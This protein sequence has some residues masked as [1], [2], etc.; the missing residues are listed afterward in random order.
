MT[1]SPSLLHVCLR[2]HQNTFLY[3]KPSLDQKMK[4]DCF[5]VK[6][7]ASSEHAA[8]LTPLRQLFPSFPLLLLF[9]IIEPIIFFLFHGHRISLIRVYNF[10]DLGLSFFSTQFPFNPVNHKRSLLMEM[11]LSYEPFCPLV[12]WFVL[13]NIPKG[14]FHFHFPIRDSFCL[15]S[16][17]L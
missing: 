5:L 15:K 1:L 9:T 13:H 8:P 10:L 6:F 4:N 16:P 3:H 14:K 12:G 7:E 2:K 11:K 17:S